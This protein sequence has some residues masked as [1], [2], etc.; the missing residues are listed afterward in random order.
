M[1]RLNITTRDINLFS[2]HRQRRY[3]K[4]RIINRAWQT[5]GTIKG[6]I[7]SGNINIDITSNL[8]RS[9]SLS[10]RYYASSDELIAQLSADIYIA[11]DCGIEDNNTLETAWYQQG[12][13]IINQGGIKVDEKSRTIDLSLA[14]LMADITGDRCGVL[15]AY[16]SIVKNSQP[17]NDVIK[18]VL[19]LTDVTDYAIDTICVQRPTSS[20]Y[21]EKQTDSDYMIP[22]DMEFSVGVSAYEILEKCVS[23][24]PY[25]RM[26]YDTYGTFFIDKVIPDKYDDSF[27]DI[28]YIT[29]KNFV[30]SESTSFDFF[31]VK[32]KI[33]VWGKDGIYYGEASDTNPESPFNINATKPMTL[34]LS[35]ADSE[36]GLDCNSI[37]DRYIDLGEK[38]MNTDEIKALKQEIAALEAIKNPTKEELEA[39]KQASSK[40]IRIG[41]QS[42]Q[43]QQEIIEYQKKISLVKVSKTMSETEKLTK[44]ALYESH[45]KQIQSFYKQK[46]SQ[47]GDELAKQ[48][49]EYILEQKC[50]LNDTITLE[51]ILL[52][53]LNEVGGKFSYQ[54]ENGDIRT[55]TI[56]SISHDLGSNRTTIT[57]AR[58]YTDQLYIYQDQLGTPEILSYETDGMTVT[59]NV[60]EVPD[61]ERYTL[62]I[63]GK[64]ALT[65]TGT[66]LVYTMPDS[67]EGTYSLYIY[68]DADKFR[69]SENSETITISFTPV[70]DEDV[71]VTNANDTIITDSGDS[72]AFV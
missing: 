35:G 39:L 6:Y 5:I 45:L 40:Y 60:S 33:E 27:V 65:S 54:L 59:I 48:W 9:A 62:C 17:I 37:Q 41:R 10:M 13:F 8:S 4:L 19:K 49:A 14:D 31:A 12:I 51:T 64:A 23:L 72:L 55:Y 43:I 16:T 18:N 15:H 30:I 69:Q 47:T 1:S 34:V 36:T 52:P 26:G 28:D 63:D 29:L 2:Q 44:I 50:R 46:V 32:N 20:Y 42:E 67:F 71:L 38:Y 25:Y 53:F 7:I 21:D 57:G 22:Y 58:F 66:T 68:A 24:Y 3:V 70:A 56:K 11:I 61:A